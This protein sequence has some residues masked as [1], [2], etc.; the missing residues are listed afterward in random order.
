MN[1]MDKLRAIAGYEDEDEAQRWHAVFVLTGEEDTVKQ[2]IDYVLKNSTIR[3]V[4]PKRTI[5]ERYQGKWY[6]K[7]KPLFPGYVL[8]Q[9]RVST[10]AYYSLKPVPGLIRILK[11]NQELYRI[12]PD[13]ISIIRHLMGESDT[14][15]IS[16]GFKQGDKVII[17][18]GPLLNLEGLITSVDCRKGRARVKLCI[19]GDERTVDLCIRVIHTA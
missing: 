8:L 2:R 5:M 19:L 12:H 13:E 4:V 1:G 9:G 18:E 3:A 16:K 11:D 14:I 10:A 15:G 7:I 17:T 6:E